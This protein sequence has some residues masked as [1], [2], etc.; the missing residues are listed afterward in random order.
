MKR[1]ILFLAFS[2]GA[3]AAPDLRR[4]IAVLTLKDGRILNNVTI[5][6]YASSAVMAKWDGG[7]GTIQYQQFPDDWRN[8]LEPMRPKPSPTQVRVQP[9]VTISTP[10]TAAARSDN[11]APSGGGELEKMMA[12]QAADIAALRTRLDA[13]EKRLRLN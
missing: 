10:E 4:S 3:T 5:V 6:S 13:I 1:I 12:Q 9:T 2:V 7:R 8:E 11:T